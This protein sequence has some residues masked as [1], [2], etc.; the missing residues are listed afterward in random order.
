ME[1]AESVNI[2]S[3]GHADSS[4]K[5]IALQRIDLKCSEEEFN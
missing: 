2:A 3:A 1:E 4:S 5:S